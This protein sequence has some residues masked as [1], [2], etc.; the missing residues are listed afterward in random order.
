VNKL[1]FDHGDLI[2]TGR[3]H[4]GRDVADAAEWPERRNGQRP[5]RCRGATRGEAI[6]R[7]VSSGNLPPNSSRKGLFRR[8]LEGTQANP[9]DGREVVAALGD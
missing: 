1:R 7:T 8:L 5:S 4:E 6:S 3:I 9:L 2:R